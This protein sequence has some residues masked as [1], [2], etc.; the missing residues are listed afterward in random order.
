MLF[1]ILPVTLPV[2]AEGK[3]HVIRHLLIFVTSLFHGS[4]FWE[5]LSHSLNR[6]EEA[7]QTRKV[8]VTYFSTESP[9]T[10]TSGSMLYFLNISECL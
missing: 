10:P 2:S 5:Q 1:A 3:P 6:N 8:S 9:P 4:T 7:V